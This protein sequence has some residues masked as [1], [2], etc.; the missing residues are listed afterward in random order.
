[1]NYQGVLLEQQ[2]FLEAFQEALRVKKT[3][4]PM[5]ENP[6]LKSIPN[7]EHHLFLLTGNPLEIQ[8]D[9]AVKDERCRHYSWP[10]HEPTT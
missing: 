9:N 6:C 3:M 7:G 10:Q 8:L 5:S 1:M 4:F 2:G